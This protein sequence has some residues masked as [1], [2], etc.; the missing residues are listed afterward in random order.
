LVMG[1]KIRG[2][3]AGA[4]ADTILLAGGGKGAGPCWDSDGAHIHRGG[5]WGVKVQAVTHAQL[6]P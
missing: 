5:G 1:G 2:G 4:H 3:E 6:G